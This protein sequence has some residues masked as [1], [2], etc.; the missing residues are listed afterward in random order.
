M[1]P[2]L[3]EGDGSSPLPSP[4]HSRRGTVARVLT[5]VRWCADPVCGEPHRGSWRVVG[6]VCSA[7]DTQSQ[8]AAFCELA[9]EMLMSTVDINISLPRF[10]HGASQAHMDMDPCPL[11]EADLNFAARVKGVYLW[12]E[13][14]LRNLRNFSFRT[15]GWRKWRS[16]TPKQLGVFFF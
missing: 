10:M 16:P 4:L 5:D 3:S 13:I 12:P 14:S 8:R 1:T 11:V 6:R 9:M 15:D 2:A 7:K